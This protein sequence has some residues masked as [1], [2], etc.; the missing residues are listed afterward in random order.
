MKPLE[1]I[2]VLEFS[3]MIT[4]SFAAM[5]MAEQ[6]ASVTKVEPIE[7]GD[8]MRFLGSN[9]GGISALFANFNRGKK[10]LRLDIK[11]EK[12]KEIIRKLAKDADVILCNF[13]PGIMDK[14]GLGSESLRKANPKLIYAAITGFGTE[15]PEKNRPAYDP[16]IQAQAGFAAVQGQGKEGPE[17]VRNLLCDKVTAY[18]A[19]QAVTAALYV[20][21]KTGEGQHIDLS[22]M[23]AGLFFVFGD[24]FMHKTLLDDDAEELPPLSQLLYDLTET[25]DGGITMSAANSAQQIGLFTALD[26]LHLLADERFNSQEKLVA[27][28]EE[29]KEILREKF[30]EFETDEILER[31][32]ENDVPAAKCLDY[33]DVLDHVQ[34]Q[35]NSTVDIVDHPILGR[36]HQVKLPAKFQG[37]RL[38]PAVGCPGHGEHT[39]ELLQGLGLSKDEIDD[40]FEHKVAQ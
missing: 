9:K 35:A 24:G 33:Q 15:G 23:D 13:R 25:K 7:L 6:G 22:M 3:T 18:T 8:P 5:M 40:L 20:R 17:L 32:S 21:E 2:N 39:V 38:E 36:M 27:H 12:G 4:A 26:Q 1:G 14:L 37:Q 31:L 19:C 10:S 16:I 34:Y 30:L 28:Y 29:L 11:D